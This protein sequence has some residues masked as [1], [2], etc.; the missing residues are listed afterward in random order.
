[1]SQQVTVIPLLLNNKPFSSSNLY[2]LPH[3]TGTAMCIY[4]VQGPEYF[5]L[6]ILYE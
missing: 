3:C 6:I 2:R 1:V 4:Y 5:V